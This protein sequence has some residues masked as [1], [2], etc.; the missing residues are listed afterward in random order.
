MQKEVIK[1]YKKGDIIFNEGDVGDNL[2]IIKKGKVGVYRGKKGSLVLLSVLGEAEFFGEMAIFGTQKKDKFR[3]ATVQAL[4]DTRLL[5]INKIKMQILLS[6]VP[7]WYIVFFNSIVD[8]LRDMNIRVKSKFMLGIGYSILNFIL[9]YAKVN[10][11]RLGETIILEDPVHLKDEICYT[12]G[13]S[14]DYYYSWLTDFIRAELIK[15]N[16]DDLKNTQLEI[17]DPEKI[18]ELLHYKKQ[19]KINK[20][21]KTNE[22]FEKIINTFSLKKDSVYLFL[23]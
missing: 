10:G 15:G 22:E 7:K 3:T 23:K 14:E 5:T 6:K 4:E 12:L 17:T 1:T 18:K 21:T 2:F 20:E 11:T 19:R 8:R 9:Y 13:V 16:V